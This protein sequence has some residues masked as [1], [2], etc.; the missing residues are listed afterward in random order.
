MYYPELNA[1]WPEGVVPEE[2]FPSLQYY[3]HFVQNLYRDISVT[4]EDAAAV[5]DALQTSLGHDA[6]AAASA[7][8][9][10]SSAA[11]AS[12]STLASLV[13]I[14]VVTEDWCGDSAVTVPYISRLAETIGVPIRIFRQSVFTDLKQWYV[15]DGT[16]HIPT[17]SVLH[18]NGEVVRELFRWIERPA[19]AHERV[20]GWVAEHPDFRELM[21]RKDSD[22]DAAKAYFKLYA[23]LLRDMSSWYRSGLWREIAREFAAGLK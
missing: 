4:P 19:A 16:T 3:R 6:P 11:V 14:V 22:D 1:V 17:V 12:S 18:D 9:T 13:K 5:A 8:V 23:Q 21:K 20:Q 7:H 15:D 10:A 2:Y